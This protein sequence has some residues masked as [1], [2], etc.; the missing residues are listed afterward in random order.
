M[1]TIVQRFIRLLLLGVVSSLGVQAQSR[2]SDVQDLGLRGNVKTVIQRDFAISD[3]DGT[4]IEELRKF[5]SVKDFDER[6]FNYLVRNYG[7]GWATSRSQFGDVVVL[8]RLELKDPVELSNETLAAA[9]KLATRD[10]LN[11][12]TM[13]QVK[14]TFDETGKKAQVM[15]YRID[16]S[17]ISKDTFRY[18]DKGRV[19][20]WAMVGSPDGPRMTQ[21][22]YDI[23]NNLIEMKQTGIGIISTWRYS[24]FKFDSKGNW[25]ERLESFKTEMTE[26]KTVNVHETRNRRAIYYF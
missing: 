17:L 4:K 12:T 24:E 20:E 25:V 23:A 3:R 22:T 9:P 6:G 10:N 8:V 18:D 26:R 13:P 11:D 14:Y 16:G 19:S 15:S 21:Y 2:V 7:T 1:N 5:V